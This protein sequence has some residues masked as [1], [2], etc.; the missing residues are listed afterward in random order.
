MHRFECAP[1]DSPTDPEARDTSSIATQAARNPHPS[2]PYS[3][4]AVTPCKPSSPILGHRSRGNALSRSICAERGAISFSAKFRVL[5]RIIEALSPRSKS[6]GRG[7]LGIMD[8]A[9]EGKRGNDLVR[10]RRCCP[11]FRRNVCVEIGARRDFRVG[12]ETF[13][14]GCGAVS[15]GGA[16]RPGR[17]DFRPGSCTP[18]E[19]RSHSALKDGGWKR[20]RLPRAERRDLEP[21]HPPSRKPKPVRTSGGYWQA[22]QKPCRRLGSV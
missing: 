2:P 18:V 19:A 11:A 12:I 4:G 8:E 7:V 3:S 14:R 1:Y 21:G 16:E 22:S 20:Q 15:M 5:S 9:P 6:K 17:A 13:S 10:E